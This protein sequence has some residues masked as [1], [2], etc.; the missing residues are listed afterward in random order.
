M[1]EVIPGINEKTFE[2]TRKKIELVRDIV[3]WIHIDILDNTLF[4]D[5]TMREWNAFKIFNGVVKFEA[6]LMVA[7]PQKYIEPLIQNGF[8][9]LIAH[10]EADTTRDFIQKTKDQH[11]EVGIAL[12]GPSELELVEPFLGDVDVVLLMMH[13]AGP[14]GQPFQYDQ[15]TKVRKVHEEYQQL[16]IEVDG[17]I[18]KTNAPLVVAA[19]ATRLVSTSYLF[20][21]NADR[22]AEAIEELRG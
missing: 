13:A 7:D 22:I 9:R 3:P 15:L 1:I 21:K 5:V 20:W 8:D 10:A 2:E 12:D 11:I 14:S 18:D 16:P 6:H 4:K 19:G 17:G